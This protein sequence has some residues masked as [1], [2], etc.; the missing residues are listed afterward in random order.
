VQRARTIDEDGSSI[1]MTFCKWLSP[2]GNWINEKGVEPTIEVDQPEYYYT[3]TADIEEPL[4]Y[5]DT[6]DRVKNIQ[7][8]LDGLGYDT[9]RT[10]GDFNRATEEAVKAFQSEHDL[11]VTGEVDAKTASLIESKVIDKVRNG[12][13]DRQMEKALEALYH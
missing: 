10:D 6:G 2:K 1:K 3:T 9:E 13:D 11:E 4:V 12:D 7:V 8:M 5:G